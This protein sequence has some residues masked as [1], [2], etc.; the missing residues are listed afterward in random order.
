MD[1]GGFQK[2]TLKDYPGKVAAI[3]FTQGCQLR[4]PYCH[5]PDLVL[6][7]RFKSRAESEIIS[8]EFFSYLKKRKGILDAVVLTGGEPL[9][10]KDIQEVIKE[11]KALGFFVKLDTNGL[12]PGLLK[13]LLEGGLLDYVALDY[14]NHAEGWN[15]ATGVKIAKTMVSPYLMWE[16]SL[17]S[18]DQGHTPYEI[19]TTVVKEIHKIDDL[20]IMGRRLRGLIKKSN[21]RWFLQSFERSQNLLCDYENLGYTLS[22]YTRDEMISFIGELTKIVPEIGLRE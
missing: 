9:L 16:K 5:N 15:K 18:L 17:L 13:N 3:C 8:N 12:L 22:S 20:K 11:I 14:K 10:Q 2:L 19:R 1:I 4:C 21:P 7:R 6:P